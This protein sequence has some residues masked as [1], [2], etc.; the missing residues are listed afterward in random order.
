LVG[1]KVLDSASLHQDDR[2]ERFSSPDEM[3]SMDGG[4]PLLSCSLVEHLS[5]HLMGREMLCAGLRLW[6]P[7]RSV[8]MTTGRPHCFLLLLSVL[9][10]EDELPPGGTLS[11]DRGFTDRAAEP[12]RDR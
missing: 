6:T 1:R 9:P 5:S 2:R 11:K 4:F 12:P 10:T 3:R 7:L 8:K